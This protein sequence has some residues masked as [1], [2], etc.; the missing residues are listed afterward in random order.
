MPLKIDARN[1]VSRLIRSNIVEGKKGKGLLG[2]S[3]NSGLRKI[4]RAG[5]FAGKNS[6]GGLVNWVWNGL[7]GFTGWVFSSALGGFT[8]SI[9]AIWGVITNNI[10]K[11]TSFN[12][13][14]TDKQL[15]ASINARNEQIA[16]IWGGV[17]GSGLGWLTAIGVGAGIA[18]LCPTIGGAALAK[19]VATSATDEAV[20]ELKAKLQAAIGQTTSLLT[21]T[22]ANTT[23]IN[24][25]NFL[26]NVPDEFLVSFYGKG[27]ADF[28]KKEWGKDGQPEISFNKTVE[29]TIQNLPGG[30]AVQNFAEQFL[31]EYWDSFVEAG[32]VIAHQLDESY[33]QSKL[34]AKQAA[35][36]EERTIEIALDKNAPNDVIVYSSVPEK[37][38]VPLCQQTININRMLHGKDIGEFVGEPFSE[39]YQSALPQQRKLT[40]FWRESKQPPYKL[41][42]KEGKIVQISIPDLK[43]NLSWKD[44]KSLCDS[45]QWG[46]CYAVG[47]FANRRKLTVWAATQDLAEK[48]VRKFATLST[49]QLI[50]INTGTEVQK[51]PLLVKK[52]TLIYPQ[53]C[54]LLFKYEKAEGRTTLDGRTLKEKTVKISLWEKEPPKGKSNLE[55]WDKN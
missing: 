50:K 19:L 5:Q 38:L 27:T 21:A 48:Q 9:S 29:D 42:N 41:L 40:M 2:A 34:A 52:T 53:Y 12:W 17:L 55:T 28:I 16:G 3:N 4:D 8:W 25:R 11:L 39:A 46:K 36:G 37:L 23:Y 13:N 35:L 14:Q 44:V 15:E 10:T 31:E 22:V 6:G 30:K 7:S 32:F 20:T 1:L 18:Y 54:T 26:R 43:P 47:T 24:Y 45:Y 49:Q 33:Q 51:N